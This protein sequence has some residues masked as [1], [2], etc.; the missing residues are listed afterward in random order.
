MPSELKEDSY[1]EVLGNVTPADVTAGGG[2]S[3]R[4]EKRRS[5]KH[6]R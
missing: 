6:Y 3:W 4:G 1:H 5:R 2:I